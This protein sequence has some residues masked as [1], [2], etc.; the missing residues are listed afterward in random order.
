M[1]DA[2]GVRIHAMD[3]IH[4][5]IDN[6]EDNLKI[7]VMGNQYIKGS[8]IDYITENYEYD[9]NNF[10][11]V[12][13][14]II[15]KEYFTALGYQHTAIDLNGKEGS[16]QFDLRTPIAESNQADFIDS[17]DVMIDIGNSEHVDN[18]YMNFKNLHDVCKVESTFIYV[19]P[20]E[21][22]WEGHCKY[23]YNLDFFEKLAEANG[24][25]ILMLEVRNERDICCSMKKKTSDEF[26]SEGDFKKLPIIIESGN[27]FNDRTLYP[28]AY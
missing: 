10:T 12:K 1:G 4:Q 27:N 23:K 11:Y 28:Y 24:Y 22:H 26:M 21:G 14:Q 18:Q 9:M 20:K 17:F 13:G 5:N 3:F 7:L 16:I 15:A 2:M 6:L 25:E 8:G 19:L